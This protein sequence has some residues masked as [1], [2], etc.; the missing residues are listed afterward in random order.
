MALSIYLAG[1]DVFLANA[2]K[3]GTRKCELCRRFG[4]E[5]LF[6][7]DKDES[8]VA[9]VAKIFR[10]NCAL[11][12]RADIGMFNLTPFRGPSADP[13]TVFELGFMFALDK[14]V[15]GYS[16]ARE[17]HSNR[18]EAYVGP[19]LGRRGQQWD[20][21]G[22]RVEDFGLSDNLMIEQA[23]REAGG[24]ITLVE[25]DEG[26]PLAA[27]KAFESCLDTV[28]RAHSDGGLKRNGAQ[29]TL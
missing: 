5:G 24:T 1:P 6:P 10:G 4:F 15:Y 13:G 12:R 7:L 27:F 8:V 2:R 17:V 16:S 22:H 20:R 26:E 19:L 21:D 11:M 29:A 3:V 23:V 28:A 9:D 14:P 18:V 25:E